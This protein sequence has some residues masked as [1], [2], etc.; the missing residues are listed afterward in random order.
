MAARGKKPAAE[1]APAAGSAPTPAVPVAGRPTTAATS[2]A[3]RQSEVETKLEIDPTAKLP[4]LTKRRRLGAVG[5]VAAAEPQSYHLDATYYDTAFLDLLRSRLTLR[6]RT[7]G[8]DAGWHLK[9]PAAQGG[10]TEVQLPLTAGEPGDVPAE[11]AGLVRGAARGR[12]LV[13]VARLQNDRI[14]RHLLDEDGQVMIE[15]ADDHV[16]ATPLLDDATSGS[17]WRELEAEIVGGTRDQLAATVD[18]LMSAGARKASS[19]SKLARALCFEPPAARR[20]KSAGTAVIASLGRQRDLMI[21]ADR[22]L[23]DGIDG[24]L[25]DARSAARRIRAILTVYSPL[26]EGDTAPALRDALRAFGSTLSAARD[27]D[28]AGQRLIAQL[29]EE[30]QEFAAAARTRLQDACGRRLTAARTEARV[31]LDSTGYL[32]MLRDIDDLVARP[33]DARAG[34]AAAGTELPALISA[35]WSRLRE[36]ADDALTDPGNIGVVHEVRTSAKTIRYATE[37]AIGAL[38]SDAVVFAS[39]LEEIQETLG[40]F[41]DAGYAAELLASLS[42]EDATDGVAGF[43]FGRLH[44]FEQAMAHGAFDEFSDVWDRVEDGELVADL[45]GSR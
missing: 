24:A 11:L 29:V 18:V 12:D 35:S 20:S 32:Q 19:A 45:G 3:T 23:R 14:V 9:L 44:A 5:I 30:P 7:G 43:T 6:R 42:L 21:T 10:R 27:L 17:Q 37:A 39:A 28:V 4:S 25:H 41:Q 26:F 1:S 22:G 33:L 13:A 15:V 2:S 38:G 16:T 40:E 8:P 34:T 31:H 36:Q